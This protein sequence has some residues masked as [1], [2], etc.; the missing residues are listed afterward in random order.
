MCL[1]S[2]TARTS[3]W[4]RCHLGPSA[5]RC[6]PSNLRYPMLSVYTDL[7]RDLITPE[8]TAT[9]AALST[10][11]LFSHTPRPSGRGGGTGLLI[12]PKWSYQALPL[13]HLT[14]EHH[15]VA[16]TLS[17]K[18]YIVVIYRP[19]EMDALL[20]CFP[21][22]GTPLVVLGDFNIQPEK[23]HSPELTDFFTTFD[24]TLSPSPPTHRARNQLRYPGT[25]LLHSLCLTITLFL[26]LSP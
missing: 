14:F 26:S 7:K 1:T 16:V 18:L 23:L 12:S 2:I 4:R 3:D 8:N 24:L 9:P 19:P 22:D 13:E 20:S 17:I 21:E 10:A 6:T 11:Y 25:L 5:R 15:A